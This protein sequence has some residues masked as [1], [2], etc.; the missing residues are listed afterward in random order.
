MPLHRRNDLLHTDAFPTR[1]TRGRRIL[2]LFHNI[3]PSRMRDRILG[4]PFS[5]IVEEFAP[6]GCHSRSPTES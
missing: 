5:R 1:P 2:R 4:A 3:H 6:A